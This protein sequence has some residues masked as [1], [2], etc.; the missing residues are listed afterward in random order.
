M[1]HSGCL[2]EWTA[3]VHV[4]ISGL[5]TLLTVWLAYRRKKADGERRKFY[6]QM[7][8]KHGLETSKREKSRAERGE[9]L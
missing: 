8:K 3:L 6:W 1:N 4:I 5:A 9:F 2:P 7:R